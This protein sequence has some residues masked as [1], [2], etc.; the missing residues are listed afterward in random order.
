[1]NSTKLSSPLLK[2][3]V[4]APHASATKMADNQDCSGQPCSS[5]S[6]SLA[7]SNS[8]CSVYTNDTSRSLSRD[9]SFSSYS[10]SS[11]T[12]SSSCEWVTESPLRQI[13]GRSSSRRYDRRD[14]GSQE[15][16]PSSRLLNS[17]RR[18]LEL[19]QD[20][21]FVCNRYISNFI[22]TPSEDENGHPQTGSKSE[23][24]VWLSRSLLS[25]P[26]GL[27]I[28][29]P[30]AK[31]SNL[32]TSE[33]RARSKSD[34]YND[35]IAPSPRSTKEEAKDSRKKKKERSKRRGLTTAFDWCLEDESA[36]KRVLALLEGSKAKV[37]RI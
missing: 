16:R 6:G 22:N 23:P 31:G 29:T 24:E 18:N 2:V 8:V 19:T 35:E 21:G 34:S 5:G 11:T 1:M 12:G 4:P 17:R 9:S 32:S 15:D 28:S 20:D 37:R 13:V 7:D 33:K 36:M 27:I 30:P 10:T 26:E 3:L 25:C 14:V